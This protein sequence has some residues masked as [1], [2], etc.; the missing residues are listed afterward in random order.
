MATAQVPHLP[1]EVLVLPTRIL[2]VWAFF[3]L[4][5]PAETAHLS[6]NKR[7]DKGRRLSKWEH[8]KKE[9]TK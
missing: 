6:M 7:L 4:D 5:P 2:D 3:G 1:L 8:K 9:K